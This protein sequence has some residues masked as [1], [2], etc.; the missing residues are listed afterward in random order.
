MPKAKPRFQI[1]QILWADLPQRRPPGHE[2]MGRRPVL[3]VGVPESIQAIPY[4]VLMVVPLTRTLLTGPLFPLL[5]AGT[6][7]LPVDSTALIYQAGAL[8][9]AR[10]AGRIG[11]L[12]AADYH[13]I[14]VGLRKLL[15]L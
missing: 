11:R 10:V 1:G 3:V 7:G 5:K 8:D 9:A 4:R 12:A 2:Q 14:A 6:G 15:Q 13:P